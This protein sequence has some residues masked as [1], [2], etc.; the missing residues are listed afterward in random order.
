MLRV[1][2]TPRWLALHLLLVAVVVGMLLLSRWQWQHALAGRQQPVPDDPAPV[3]LASVHE[4]GQV[5]PGDLA[6]RQVDVAGRYDAGAQVLVPNRSLDGREGLWVVTPLVGEGGAG[7]LVVRGWVPTVDDAAL[8]VP[9]GEVTVTGRLQ[10]SETAATG[11]GVGK[12][13]PDGQVGEVG[14]AAM[15][16]RV[17]YPLYDGYVALRTQEPPAA[18]EPVPLP[19]RPPTAPPKE[20]RLQNYAYAVQWVLFA[21]F[22]VFLWWRML[23]DAARRE[24]E[25]DAEPEPGQPSDPVASTP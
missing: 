4:T 7:V 22:A 5:L 1:A 8:A 3:A 18:A 11:V 16:A 19:E 9:P 10:P 20:L 24:R 15:L 14:A 25:P 6:G 2:L 12:R 17:D 23:R 13:L 21:G